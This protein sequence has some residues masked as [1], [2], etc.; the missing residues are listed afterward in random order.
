[1]NKFITNE[2]LKE[3]HARELLKLLQCNNFLNYFTTNENLKELHARELLKLQPGCNLISIEQSI[4]DVLGVPQNTISVLIDKIIKNGQ[5]SDFDKTFEPF[6]YN[7]WNTPKQDNQVKHFG[8]FPEI[9][10]ENLSQMII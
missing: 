8:A 5:M 10:M 6:L 7:I 3:G 2:N 9:F 1:M 4:A